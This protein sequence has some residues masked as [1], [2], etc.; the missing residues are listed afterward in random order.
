MNEV[1]IIVALVA[2]TALFT[3]LGVRAFMRRAVS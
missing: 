3:W 1:A 2:M